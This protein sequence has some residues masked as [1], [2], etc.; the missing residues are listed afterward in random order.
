MEFDFTNLQERIEIEYGSIAEFAA[1][2]GLSP[3]QLVLR[4]DGRLQ[5]LASEIVEIADALDI[6]GAEIELYF[7]IPKFDKI[8]LEGG[9]PLDLRVP[10]QNYNDRERYRYCAAASPYNFGI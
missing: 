2:V 5:F 3:T 7:F 10:F 1:V 8:E 6:P 4:L 9:L